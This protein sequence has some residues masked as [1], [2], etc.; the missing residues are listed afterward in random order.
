[1]KKLAIIGASYLQQPL[2]LKAK[3]LGL[4]TL[5]FAWEKGAVCKNLVDEFYPISIVEKEKILF[6]CQEKHID[7]ICTIASDS[8]APTVAYVAENLGLIGNSYIS[9]I[10]AS[11]KFAMRRIFD[12]NHCPSPQYEVVSKTTLN[13]FLSNIRFAYN[14]GPKND[15]IVKP[16]D[17]SGSLCVTRVHSI[18]EMHNA[19]NDAIN[20]SFSKEAI[21]EEYVEGN[22]VSVECISWHGT[23]YILQITDKVVEPNHFIEIAHHQPSILHNDIQRKISSIVI[24]A[25]NALQITNGASHSELKINAD[26][27]IYIMEIGARMGGGFIGSHLVQLSTGYDYVKA[28]IQIAMGRFELPSISM[29]KCSGVYFL[30]P[31]TKHILPYIEEFE[32]FNFV[33]EAKLLN[34][35]IPQAIA[36]G[37]RS[38]YFIYQS[39]HRI[40]I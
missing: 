32:K 39:D 37:D 22:E 34:P 15:W 17:R 40:L 9:A 14:G 2:A 23:H 38:G 11:N 24:E 30:I 26:G 28:V 31:E 18:E 35:E 29:H 13:K 8:A 19:I 7:G 3:E 21:V 6:I 12:V 27:D 4:Y 16:T 25:L 36:E 5:C 20:V 1:M 10:N 33:R